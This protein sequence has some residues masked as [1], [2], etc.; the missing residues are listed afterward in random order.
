MTEMDIAGFIL[1]QKCNFTLPILV[2]YMD[3]SPDD[4]LCPLRIFS[5]NSNAPNILK[6][7]VMARAGCL[8]IEPL[9]KLVNLQRTFR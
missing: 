6:L 2:L 7:S 3:N 1:Y 8:S 5:E 4:R 9:G